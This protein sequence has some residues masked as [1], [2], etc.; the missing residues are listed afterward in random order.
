[1]SNRGAEYFAE[2]KAYEGLGRAS[3]HNGMIFMAARGANVVVQ[4]ASTILLARILSP[5]DFG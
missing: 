3:L 2:N 5:H 1:M 4:L